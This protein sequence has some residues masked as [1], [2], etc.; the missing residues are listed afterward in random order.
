MPLSTISQ[1]YQAVS[2]IGGR[3]PEYSEKTNDLP[4]ITVK[5]YSYN[6]VSSM[7]RH[8]RDLNSQL[9]W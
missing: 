5:L 8:E 6:V 9:Q 3:K 2:F 4:H 7:P 1:L